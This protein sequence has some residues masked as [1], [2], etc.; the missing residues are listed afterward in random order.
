MRIAVISNWHYP[1]PSVAAK[2][3]P[4]STKTI[5]IT[6]G[7]TGIGLATAQHLTQLPHFENFCGHFSG[8]SCPRSFYFTVALQF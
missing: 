2:I 1:Q 6:G 7:T 3:E 4:M 5:L 8:D